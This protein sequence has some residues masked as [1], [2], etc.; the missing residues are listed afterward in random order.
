MLQK[1]ETT[2]VEFSVFKEK[3]YTVKQN[4]CN[5][6]NHLYLLFLS[7]DFRKDTA[8]MINQNHLHTVGSKAIYNEKRK[9]I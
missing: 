7:F 1:W 8:K 6:N 3:I 9:C 4:C 5:S 2:V